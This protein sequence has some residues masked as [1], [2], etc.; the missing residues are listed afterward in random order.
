MSPKA[1]FTL[2]LNSIPENISQVEPF[3]QELKSKYNLPDDLYFNMLLVLTE[4]VNNSILHG[5]QADPCKR[6]VVKAQPNKASLSF[7]ISDEGCG[8]NPNALPDPTS[9]ACIC[10]PNGRGVFLMRQLSDHL[11]YSNNGRRVVIRFNIN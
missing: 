3:L 11:Q 7:T 8:F 6:V 5:N 2:R 10:N 1:R 9:P 4:A